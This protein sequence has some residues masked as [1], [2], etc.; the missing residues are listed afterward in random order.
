MS[1]PPEN[2]PPPVRA[3]VFRAMTGATPDV[4]SEAETQA[5][6]RLMNIAIGPTGQSRRVA[7]FLLA[8]WNAGECG[9]FD[10]TTLWGIDDVI[11]QDMITVFGLIARVNQYPDALGYETKF[12]KIVQTWRPE[13]SDGDAN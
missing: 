4:P 7:D 5:L 9:A 12:K 3:A 1:T 11:A 10:L 2:L 8:W 6:V 13:L